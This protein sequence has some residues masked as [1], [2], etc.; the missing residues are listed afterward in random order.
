MLLTTSDAQSV[1]PSSIP[2]HD[3]K[4]DPQLASGVLGTL[5]EKY[6]VVIGVSG[7][8]M[9]DEVKEPLVNIS[10]RRGSLNQV[11]DATVASDDPS[12]KWTTTSS[13]A[14]HFVEG[15][16]L[17]LVEVG[18]RKFDGKKLSRFDEGGVDQIPEVSAWLQKD[19]CIVPRMEI[20][21]G[22]RPKEWP[23][24]EVHAMGVPLCAVLDE[25][26]LKSGRY[27]WSLLQYSEQPCRMDVQF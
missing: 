15:V 10:L 4:L 11:F 9:L 24:F 26:A 13:G 23:P 1:P 8:V 5:A 3:L 6:H 18:V 14:V 7:K 12:Y 27:F 25:L 19:N 22:S 16:P 20:V 2:V 21:V 17:P